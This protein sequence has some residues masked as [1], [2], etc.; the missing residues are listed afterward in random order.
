[1]RNKKDVLENNLITR[2]ITLIKKRPYIILIIIGV[3]I[4]FNFMPDNYSLFELALIILIYASFLFFDN[5]KTS[6]D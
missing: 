4:V 1:M 6:K 5:L 2:T 3:D